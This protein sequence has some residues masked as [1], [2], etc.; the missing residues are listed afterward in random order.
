MAESKNVLLQIL[1][2]LR[3]AGKGVA[4]GEDRDNLKVENLNPANRSAL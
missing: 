3:E 4:A 2:Q 1:V